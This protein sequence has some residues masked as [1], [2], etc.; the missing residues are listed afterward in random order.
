M[1]DEARGLEAPDVHVFRGL[2][3]V[4]DSDV[5][6]LF[7]YKTGRLNEQ[8][9]RNIDR[10]GD[11]FAFQL[12]DEEFDILRSQNATS[13]HGGR[14]TPPWVYTEHGVVMAATV[15]KSRQAAEASRFIVRTFVTAR[16]TQLDLPAGTNALPQIPAETVMPAAHR[17]PPNLVSKL[18]AA[19]N[20][21]LDAIADP[22]TN[23]TVRDEARAIALE[24]LDAI[25]EQMRKG[26]VQNEKT[27]AEV[28]KLL[29]EA[30]EIDAQIAALR[31]ESE[32]RRL[33]F[34]AKE[35]RIVLEVQRYFESGSIDGLLAVLKDLGSAPP[36]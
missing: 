29:K 34:V 35:L 9:K 10:F 6:L 4:L 32:H 2:P 15:L 12:D 8:T 28:Q 17:A 25:R 20:R 18:D 33:A 21:V 31:I 11:D 23:T 27:L 14:R 13:R 30:E 22:E 36:G 7:G 26:K 16:R 24:G 3:V 1:D 19:L 5:A